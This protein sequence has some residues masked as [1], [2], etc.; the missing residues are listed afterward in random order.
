MWRKVQKIQKIVL[1]NVIKFF[2]EQKSINSQIL[3][4]GKNIKNIKERSGQ[5]ERKHLFSFLKLNFFSLSQ[6]KQN[7]KRE[8]KMKKNRKSYDVFHLNF[9]KYKIY[10]NISNNVILKIYK[11]FN[12]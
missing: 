9:D 5:G 3:L 8:K 4:Y 6:I 2:N 10:N 12:V 1:K 11:I 7:R